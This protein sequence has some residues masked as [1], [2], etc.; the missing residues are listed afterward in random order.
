MNVIRTAIADVLIL[1]PRLFGDARGYFLESWNAQTFNEAVGHEVNFVQDNHSRSR[2][3]VL[4][5][6]HFQ[7]IQPQGKRRIITIRRRKERCCGMIRHWLS[8]G[9]CTRFQVSSY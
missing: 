9:R 1:E 2:Q 5:G 7:R 4:R 8:R 3:G 6:L